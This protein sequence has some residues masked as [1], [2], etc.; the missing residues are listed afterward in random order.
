[1]MDRRLT[2][3]SG[4]VALDSLRG[5][6]EAQ[7]F[8]AGH[9]VQVVVPLAD[10]LD[11]PHGRRDRQVLLGEALTLIDRH[12]GHGFV[13]AAKDGY[14]GWLRE[15]TFGEG[16]PPSHWIAAPA[17]HLYSAP[18]VQAPETAALTLGARVQVLA[19]DGDFAR[20]PAGYVPRVH[21]RPLGQWLTDP[22]AVAESLLGTPY[23]WGGNSRAG[24]DCS[25]LV[26]AALLACGQPCP[27]DSDMQRALGHDLPEEAIPMRG[28][29][30]FWRGHVAMVV[31]RQ[32]LIHANGHHMAVQY[33][34]IAD[35]IT[36][37]ETQGGG[38]VTARR[39][40]AG[41]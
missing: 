28:D 31:D 11:A 33:E 2:P 29:L 6:V 14:C 27:G 32:R 25:G 21:L 9:Q 40:M 5:Q 12:E 1:M 16:T 36:R 26:Q 39:R 18:R 35:C 38:P 30:L 23:L 20:T 10:L 41:S 7:A 22:A 24:I 15:T 8:T 4:R 19:V 17:S 37:I 3:S 34:S 13:Q